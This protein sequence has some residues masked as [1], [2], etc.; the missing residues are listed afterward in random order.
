ML[1]LATG[2]SGFSQ[3]TTG[4]IVGVIH[5][6]TGAVLP[7]AKVI[8]TSSD[9]GRTNDIVTNSV[10]QYLV[11]LPIGNYEIT[12]VLP[13]FQPFTTRGISL[14]LNDRLQVNAK[15]VVGAVETLTVTAER[16]IQPTSDVRNLIQPEAIRELPLLTRTPIQLVTLVPGVS[17]DLRED[18]CFC[19]QGNLDITVNGARRSSVN[20]LLDGASNVNTYNNFTLVTTPSLDAIQE[21]TVITS[22]YQAEW[23]RNGGGLVNVV[24]KAG[25]N[26]FA[27]SAYEFLRNDGLNANYFFRNMA[28]AA[29]INSAPPRLRYNNFGFT[30]G[31]PALPTRKNMFFFFSG[32]WRRSTRAKGT[33]GHSGSRSQLAQRPGESE[34]RAA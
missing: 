13:N 6:Q 9:T 29:Q 23:A 26:R 2:R 25:R 15:L 1:L 3:T 11:T 4:T 14:H 18:A 5:D 20:W 12:F 8:L 21:I 10:G 34:L 24:T 31:G 27:G 19:D 28:P 32:D 30:L 16:M 33:A 17:S 22:T 7:G